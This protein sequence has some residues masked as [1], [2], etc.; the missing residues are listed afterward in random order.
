M[1]TPY[2]ALSC[3]AFSLSAISQE[4]RLDSA[5]PPNSRFPAAWY[6]HRDTREAIPTR[7]EPITGTPY[8]G[9]IVSTQMDPAIAGKTATDRTEHILRFRDGSGRTRWE[10]LVK[11]DGSVASTHMEQ[12][13]KQIEVD[14]VVTHCIFQ[15]TQPS[16]PSGQPTATVFCSPIVSFRP[17]DMS[18]GAKSQAASQT[19]AG[20]GRTLIV[21][22]LGSRTIDG[23]N[24]L[25]VRTTGSV[26]IPPNGEL[27]AQTSQ[28]VRECWWSP[29][30]NESLWLRTVNSSGGATL[31][32]KDIHAEEPD[33]ALFYPPPNYQIVSRETD[34]YY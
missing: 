23:Y 30:L 31:A 4:P 7:L 9:I 33:P 16:T 25:G 8:S 12:D 10:K 6:Q 14:D 19:N 2:I 17:W 29:K 1:K 11:P 13:S 26:T 18:F 34:P 3:I 22:P 20:P 28:N 27:P 15:W 24:I 5:P 32:L 21:E